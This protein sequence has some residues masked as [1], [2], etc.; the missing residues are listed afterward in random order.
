MDDAGQI[1]R[2]RFLPFGFLTNSAHSRQYH[3][4]LGI[5]TRPTQPV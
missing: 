5:R 3:L 1:H 2:A 4:P